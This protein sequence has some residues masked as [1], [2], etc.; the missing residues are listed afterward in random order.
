MIKHPLKDKNI[1]KAK[2]DLFPKYLILLSNFKSDIKE[3][4]N[5]A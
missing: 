5:C 1:F 2:K 3:I 4:T